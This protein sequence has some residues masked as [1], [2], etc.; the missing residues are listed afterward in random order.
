MHSFDAPSLQVYKHI[1]E[2]KN[3]VNMLKR[4]DMSCLEQTGS[5]LTIHSTTFM[6]K[7]GIKRV[8]RFNFSP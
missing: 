4:T 3:R 6:R 5:H 2:N 7:T 8:E 1:Q